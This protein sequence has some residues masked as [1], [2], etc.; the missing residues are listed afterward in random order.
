MAS[1]RGVALDG[2][3]VEGVA[4]IGRDP[5]LLEA[6]YRRHIDAVGLFVA[7]RVGDPHSAADL[8][9][10]VFLAAM[11]SAAGYRG[12]PGGE[13][14]WLYGVARN[15]VASERRRSARAADA[16][17]RIAGR[18]L[19]DADDIERLEERIDAEAAARRTYQAVERLSEADRA[20]F[21][22][23]GVD[24]LEVAEAAA[25]LGIRPVSARVRLHR[26][27]R[28]L[29]KELGS[30][31]AEPHRATRKSAAAPALTQTRTQAQAEA[32]A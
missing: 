3:G 28:R 1:E 17:R 4:G 22:L 12:G 10:E 29:A 16:S 19:L 30:P 8:T 32:K 24:G 6:F 9:A 13:R 20:V 21:E 31:T 14:A 15:V 5:A 23:V 11:G 7:R 26:A 2:S 27:R 18:R 25:A